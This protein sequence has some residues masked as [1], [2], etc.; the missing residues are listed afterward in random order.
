M[1]KLIINT[2]AIIFCIMMII[3]NCCAINDNIMKGDIDKDGAITKID[4]Q[5]VLKMAAGIE[6]IT[7]EAIEIAD[8]NYDNMITITDAR[9]ILI[10]AE[11]N[12]RAIEEQNHML[13]RVYELFSKLINA[14]IAIFK[15]AA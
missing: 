4:A 14:I 2:F 7:S 6:P 13:N 1:K 12:E 8:M 15:T 3:P 11:E 10:I 9:E 5:I